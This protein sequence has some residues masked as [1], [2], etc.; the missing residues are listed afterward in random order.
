MNNNETTLA[1][2]ELE[3]AIQAV[4]EVNIPSKKPKNPTYGIPYGDETKAAI[5]ELTAALSAKV[6]VKVTQRQVI[7]KC[8]EE[9]L[10]QLQQEVM[11]EQ[12]AYVSLLAAPY[13]TESICWVDSGY[14]LSL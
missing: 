11:A 9:G 12:E 6:G 10:K 5:A 8:F 2:D 14:L 3:S 7:I 1:P 13:I 4:K